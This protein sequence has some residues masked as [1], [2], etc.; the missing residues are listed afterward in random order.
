M[1]GHNGGH[2]ILVRF[3]FS[4]ESGERQ[5]VGLSDFLYLPLLEKGL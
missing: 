5:E 2:V 3:I 4:D 1:T